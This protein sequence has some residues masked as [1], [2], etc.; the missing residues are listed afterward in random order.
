MPDHERSRVPSRGRTGTCASCLEMWIAVVGQPIPISVTGRCGDRS[1]CSALRTS[2]TATR[3]SS[4]SSACMLAG[5]ASGC[6]ARQRSTKRRSSRGMRCSRGHRG[7]T[8]S[9]C[10]SILGIPGPVVRQHAPAHGLHDPRRVDLPQ[11]VHLAIESLAHR[12][13]AA[14]AKHLHCQRKSPT[15]PCGTVDR[16]RG[17]APHS[18]VEPQIGTHEQVARQAVLADHGHVD[19]TSHLVDLGGRGTSRHRVIVGL[20]RCNGDLELGYGNRHGRDRCNLRS[21]HDLGCGRRPCPRWR[22]SSI[23]CSRIDA[24]DTSN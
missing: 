23:G 6:R 7:R 17:T 18:G 8:P 12:A 13:Q 22:S 19:G 11:D 14:G 4:R 21:N 20:A 15:G 5:R 16:R 3:S 1:T 10:T 2:A 24:A 9:M